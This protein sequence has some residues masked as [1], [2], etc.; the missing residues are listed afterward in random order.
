MLPGRLGRE[1]G[2]LR[3]PLQD[4]GYAPAVG[5]LRREK[6]G[7]YLVVEQAG[8]SL[9]ARRSRT[10]VLRLPIFNADPPARS[11]ACFRILLE[12]QK[13]GMG[14]SQAGSLA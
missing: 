9:E 8:S 14:C 10:N 7:S 4:S 2:P 12:M 3:A 1:G 6:G 13:G 5:S 11:G